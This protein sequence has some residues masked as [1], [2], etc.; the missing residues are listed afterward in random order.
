MFYEALYVHALHRINS[1]LK[2]KKL[3]L[4]VNTI[5]PVPASDPTSLD[6]H[7]VKESKTQRI[8]LDGVKDHLIP[9]LAENNTTKD[10]WDSLKI[11][12]EEKNENRKMALWDKLHG[13]RMAKGESL[14]RYLAQFSQV[15]DELEV[16]GEVISNSELVRIDLKVFT[17]EWVVFVKC[18]WGRE[19]LPN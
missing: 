10:M 13:A 4:F 11:L 12:Y 6:V 5:V 16:V 15:K 9:H 1:V 14:A 2:E 3:W 8:I 7:E 17:K 18:V 19:K